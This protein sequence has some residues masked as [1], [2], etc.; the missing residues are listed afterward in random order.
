VRTHGGQGGG[1]HKNLRGHKRTPKGLKE[2]QD[3][4]WDPWEAYKSPITLSHLEFDIIW[5]EMHI[6][7]VQ[8]I[9]KV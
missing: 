6:L 5:L 1:R 7:E 2:L 8:I 4:I 9:F 3:H